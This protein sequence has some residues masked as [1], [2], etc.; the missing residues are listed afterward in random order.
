MCGSVLQCVAVCCSVL[1]CVAVCCSVSQRGTIGC[2]VLYLSVWSSC[3]LRGG[4]V[5]FLNLPDVLCRVC[6]SMLQCVVVWCSVLQ[7]M[8][9]CVLQCEFFCHLPDVV[10][11]FGDMHM[12]YVCVQESVCVYTCNIAKHIANTPQHAT[13]RCHTMQH[14]AS[15][16]NSERVVPVDSRGRIHCKELQHIATHETT[17]QSITRILLRTLITFAF[18]LRPCTP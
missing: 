5:F 13:T 12:M 17:A 6:C 9:Q 2:S 3:R 14:P 7:C 11:S 18:P 16:C 1:Q 15:Q 8:L 4:D 10:Y